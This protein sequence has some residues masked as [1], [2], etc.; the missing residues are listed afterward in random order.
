MLYWAGLSGAAFQSQVANGFE[1]MLSI[2][3]K[4]LAQ[5]NRTSEGAYAIGASGRPHG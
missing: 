3:Y 5:H 1:V 4:L 2:T